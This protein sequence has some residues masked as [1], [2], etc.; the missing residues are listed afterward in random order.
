[1]KALDVMVS[2]VITVTPETLV[3][4]AAAILLS[5]R[6]SGVPVVDKGTL[7]GILSEGDLLRRAE[8]GTERR[9]SWLLEMLTR[10]D[11]IAAD[12]VKSHGRKVSDVMTR[13]PVT[14]REDS[15]LAEVADLMESRQIKRL[16]VMRDDKVVG[17]VTRAN[18]LQAFAT[19]QRQAAQEVKLDDRTIRAR[20]LKT[21]DEANLRRPYGLNVTVQNGNVDL[22]GAVATNEEKNAI[23]IATEVTPGVTGVID[24]ILVQPPMS[25]G[26]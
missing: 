8:A 10:S 17:I 23:R 16:P 1:M 24:N 7:V 15:E 4:D 3:A 5:N 6:I 26:I 14:V 19:M 13:H 22:W 2:P 18:L 25:S 12:Y 21:I 20:V 9:R 11:T